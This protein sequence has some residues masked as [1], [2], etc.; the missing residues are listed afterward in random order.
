MTRAG[1]PC[2]AFRRSGSAFCYFHDESLADFRSA[3]SAK[4]G[5]TPRKALI[6]SQL[7]AFDWYRHEPAEARARFEELVRRGL[8][9]RQISVGAA[10]LF[11]KDGLRI[12]IDY[13]CWW[14]KQS[15][16]NDAS[17]AAGRP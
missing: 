7:V 15:E 5:R 9:F 4:G 17:R 16:G 14:R 3:M 1:V 10:K 11:L 2:N 6:V 12:Y 13:A 8:L